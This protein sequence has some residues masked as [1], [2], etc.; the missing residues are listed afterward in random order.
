MV[1]VRPGLASASLTAFRTRGSEEPSRFRPGFLGGG[2]SLVPF[3]VIAIL[4]AT[5]GIA[6][7]GLDMGA[8]VRCDANLAPGGRDGELIDARF[9]CF[10]ADRIAGP[11]TI[12][13]SLAAALAPQL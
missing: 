8:L 6:T 9:N 2:A 11:I 4:Q 12:G 10:I 1:R 3:G 5:L 13:E 7:D